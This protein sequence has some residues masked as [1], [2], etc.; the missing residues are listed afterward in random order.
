MRILERG[1]GG[2]TGDRFRTTCS[3]G[4]EYTF[5]DCD[6]IHVESGAVFS[7]HNSDKAVVSNSACMKISVL[8]MHGQKT[9]PI[10]VFSGRSF[11][12][13]DRQMKPT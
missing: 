12:R 6:I 11:V 3:G 7:I 9:V 13:T 5:R 10:S 8:K 4:K 2:T 1:M